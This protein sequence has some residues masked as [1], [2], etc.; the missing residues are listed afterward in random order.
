MTKLDAVIL[1]VDLIKQTSTIDCTII[2][3]GTDGTVLAYQS[4]D[5]MKHVPT[6][7]G[8]HVPEESAIYQCLKT[9]EKIAYVLPKAVF[10]VKVRSKV[11]PIFGDNGEL[12]GALSTAVS[13]DTQDKLHIAA[14]NIAA[15]AEEIIATTEALGS[16]AACLAQDLGK[17]KTGSENVLIK[18][19]NTDDILK[20]VSD[21]AAN[22]NLLGL[23]AAI[24]AARAGEQG[25]GFAVVAG[26]MRKMAVSSENSVN[27]IK[28][29]LQDIRIGTSD[30]VKTIAN[31]A[32][33]SER[34]VAATL[35]ITST[36]QSLAATAA[37]IERV[38]EVV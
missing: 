7:I 31:T 10:G 27:Q 1:S 24:E 13:M 37:E 21:V 8:D 5:F 36:M 18:I 17:G 32:E 16:T 12:L 26:E 3:T 4:A 22:S 6:K 29:I 9:K 38:A 19:N 30:V 11:C 2:V 14:Q 34:Q 23:N 28:K 25:R 33:I 35:E 20:F 15:T